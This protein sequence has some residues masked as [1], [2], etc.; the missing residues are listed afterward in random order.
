[1]SKQNGEITYQDCDNALL[2]MWM[3]KI[4]TDGEYFRISNKLQEAMKGA[5]DE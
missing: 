5:D 2:F 4:L 3:E 1:M